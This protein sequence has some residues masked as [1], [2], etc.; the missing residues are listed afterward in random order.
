MKPDGW[1]F[2]QDKGPMEYFGSPDHLPEANEVA[3]YELREPFYYERYF[4]NWYRF[5]YRDRDWT[6]VGETN[7]PNKMLV[8]LILLKG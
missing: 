8:E 7:V 5:S 3:G 6:W 4:K 1:I 2:S